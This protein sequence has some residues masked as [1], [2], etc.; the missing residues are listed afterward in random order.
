MARSPFLLGA[1]SEHERATQ[2]GVARICI[3]S[4]LLVTTGLARRLFGVPADQD[5][6]ALRLVSRL[7]G[8][9][10]IVLGAWAL[11]ARDQGVGQRRVCYQLNAVT[12]AT[13]VGIL[14]LGG[15]R[16]KGLWRTAAMGTALGGSALLAWLDLIKDV[17]EAAA[18]EHYRDPA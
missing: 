12:D 17:D 2:I 7:L 11:A 16:G 6:G 10:N 9:R 3:G 15:V 18:I 13:D 8:I 5:N 14:V 1:T 4:L